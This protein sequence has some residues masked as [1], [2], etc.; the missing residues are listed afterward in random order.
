MSACIDH[1]HA[2][3]AA[4]A[5]NAELRSMH[6]LTVLTYYA[7]HPSL[8]KPWLQVSY[9]STLYRVFALDEPWSSVLLESHPRGV[10]RRKS[11]ASTALLKSA[12]PATMPDWV[13]QEPVP[14][15]LTVTAIDLEAPSG[16]Q[17]RV[18]TWAK[19]V[20]EHRYLPLGK[21]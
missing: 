7:Q 4:E 17:Q 19:S 9:R 16:Q 21:P 6:G 14:G 5:E 3:L 18:E 8:T 2:L 20:A 13:I 1:F 10:G 11:A 15:E 12:A